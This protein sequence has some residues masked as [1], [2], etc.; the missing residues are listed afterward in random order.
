MRS[1]VSAASPALRS[2]HV[3]GARGAVDL[4]SALRS[5]LA[6]RPPARALATVHELPHA[7]H[8]YT[9]HEKH[10]FVQKILKTGIPPFAEKNTGQNSWRFLGESC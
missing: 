4:R 7:S 6:L 3:R 8:F 9:G 2:Q 5:W 10:E 1:P